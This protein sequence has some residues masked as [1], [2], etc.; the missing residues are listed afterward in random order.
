MGGMLKKSTGI[1]LRV[2]QFCHPPEGH[3]D[4][5]SASEGSLLRQTEMLRSL[6]PHCV[7]CSAGV[8]QH[9]T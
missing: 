6:A 7:W 2:V 4:D 9:D 5:V 1:I 3:R 8:A